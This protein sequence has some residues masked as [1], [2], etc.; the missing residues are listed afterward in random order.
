LTIERKICLE[1]QKEFIC[2]KDNGC[3]DSKNACLCPKCI[4]KNYSNSIKYKEFLK[5]SV[6][7]E[8]IKNPYK[9]DEKWRHKL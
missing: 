2:D 9:I 1:C 5:Y 8:G 7:W 3:P 6:C 4:Y